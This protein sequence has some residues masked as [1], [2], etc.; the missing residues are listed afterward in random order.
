VELR[1]SNQSIAYQIQCAKGLDFKDME[2]PNKSRMSNAAK[3]HLKMGLAAIAAL[4]LL[5]IAI[6]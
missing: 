4:A 5:R 2:T 3:S 6:T 1:Q